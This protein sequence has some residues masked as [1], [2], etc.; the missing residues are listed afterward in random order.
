VGVARKNTST[1]FGTPQDCN[2]PTG[3]FIKLDIS[4]R[5]AASEFCLEQRSLKAQS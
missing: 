1:N 4:K 5:D 3:E 2:D